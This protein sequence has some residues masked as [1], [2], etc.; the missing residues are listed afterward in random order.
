M[1]YIEI[2]M[3]EQNVTTV[4]LQKCDRKCSHMS[5]NEK[6][7]N[8]LP[9]RKCIRCRKFKIYSEFKN[10]NKTCIICRE[11]ANK[12]RYNGIRTEKEEKPKIDCIEVEN[13]IQME[14]MVQIIRIYTCE[15][16]K[17]DYTCDIK[18]LGIDLGK[19]DKCKECF[20]K[21]LLG[22]SE[23]CDY[24][25]NKQKLCNEKFCLC[26]YNRS[27]MPYCKAECWS[28]KNDK[29]PR[30]VFKSTGQ[31]Y[32]FDCKCG[33]EF[34]TKLNDGSWC[35]YC[36]NKQLCDK[37]DCEQCNSKS[38]AS[39][40]MSEFWSEEN[41]GIIPRQVFKSS[42]KK[43][44]FECECGHEFS[45]RLSDITNGCWCTYCANKQLCDRD[46]CKV[47]YKKSF[48][49]HP[50]SKYWS[51]KNK[52][53]PRQVF[54][55]S[56]NKY[57]FNCE[58]GH[59]FETLLANITSGGQW[60]PYCSNRKLCD[61]NDC[62]QC[63]SKSFSSHPMSKFWSERNEELPRQVFK[64][65]GK[66][67]WFDC[68]EC[69]NEF[70]KVLSNVTNGSWCPR[71]RNKTEKKLY[72]FLS[73]LSSEWKYQG[74]FDWCKSDKNRHL[75]FDFHNG[76]IKVIIELDGAQHF[77]Q[78]LNWNSPE[79]TQITD[80]YKFTKAKNNGYSMIRVLQEDVWNDKN[81]WK[82]KLTE[83]LNKFPC[84]EPQ[85]TFIGNYPENY[86]FFLYKDY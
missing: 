61:N 68:E 12:C 34:S 14:Q 65:T 82:E 69:K 58:C 73:E 19:V 36:S 48:M 33:H 7:M 75:P 62:G 37:D 11:K 28:I 39:H 47:C 23:K 79:A 24:G 83:E 57:I 54:M 76:N 3:S 2:E 32:I 16:C 40:P 81:D 71:C 27:F 77:T 31:K 22:T 78:V 67:Y 9:T 66:K 8:E 13:D 5:C 42:G 70:E 44:I 1:N 53:I 51:K 10:N 30:Q 21:M 85:L 50:K 55:S 25:G 45:I 64:S 41:K 84:D 29:K 52:E 35:P 46:D 60:C 15:D 20:K 6:N 63:H 43:Y 4:K 74:R 26:C 56:G 38:F 72:K 86:K 49:G 17:A 80:K 59:E 18:L